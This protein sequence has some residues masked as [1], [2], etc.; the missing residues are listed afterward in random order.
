MLY[1][2]F[3]LLGILVYVFFAFP[4]FLMVLSLWPRRVPPATREPPVAV[5]VPARNEASRIALKISNT[6][7]C[8][9][10]PDRL[11][12]LI[13]DDG[14]ADGTADIARQIADPRLRVLSFPAAPG[15]AT[16]VNALVQATTA[17]VLVLTDADVTIEMQSVR[18]LVRH[19]ADPRVGA[20]CGRRAGPDRP[21]HRMGWPARLY[22]LYES[23]LKRG[24]GTFSRVLGGEGCLYALRREC[25]RP[26]PTNVPD[27]FVNVLRALEGGRRVL[28]END[29][30][31][32]EDMTNTV[33]SE[34]VRKRRTVARGIRGLLSVR[35]LLNPFRYP[36][37]SALL[38][39]HKILRWTAGLM[40]LALFVVSA[41]LLD[42]PVVRALFWAQ[43]LFYAL[44]L[45]GWIAGQSRALT[46]FRAMGYFV[47]VN[48]AATAGILDVLTGRDWSSWNVQ[49][50]KP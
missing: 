23:S 43:V 7:A 16:V 30:V 5:L 45:G 13:G 39:S 50:A 32:C 4:A 18:N 12:I 2:F 31:S 40:M 47:L 19:F 3:V 35:S 36:L 48:L 20:V 33:R 28:Y 42:H 29:A 49:R 25:F 34:F 9:Y 11:E 38:L 8:D 41:R 14:S 24:E 44:A 6:F 1:V 17:E 15:K 21:D 27:D 10:P 46:P 37:I 26:L 22:N